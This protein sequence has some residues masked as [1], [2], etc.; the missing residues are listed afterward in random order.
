[1][2]AAHGASAAC[3]DCSASSCGRAWDNRVNERILEKALSLELRHFEDSE[4]YDKMQNAR[5]EASSRPLSLVMQA[6]GVGPERR[7]PGRPLRAPAPALSLERPG[8]GGASACPPSWPR[9]ASPAS[10]FRLVHLAGAGGA[11]AQLPR[12][13]PH[14]R[15]PREGGEALRPGAARPGPLPRALRP[16]LRRGPPPGRAPHGRGVR[17]RPPLA[18]R[19]S[20]ACTRWWRPG[21][22]AATITLGDLT[23]YLAGLPPGAG[24]G[25]GHPG[26]RS[27][28]STRTRSTCRTSSPSWP[29]RP[30]ASGPGARPPW[31]RPRGGPPHRARPRLLPL[32]RARGLGAARGVAHPRAGR[33]ARPG[34]RERRRQEHAGEAPAAPLRPDRGGH[35][36]RAASTCA[37][38][39]R[40]T[41]RERVGAVFQ[42]FVRYQFTAA[43]ERRA[44]QPAAPRRPPPHRGGGAARRRR[45]GGR[46]AA[47]RL[48]HR[49]RR[50]VRGRARALGRPV[51]E[52]GGGPRPSCAT[53]G[54]V[55]LLVL[56]EPTAAIDAEAEHELFERFRE[57]AAG[58][59]AIVISHRFSTVR[60]RRPDRRAARRA[61][62]W[63]WAATGSCSPWADATRTSSAS[64]RPGTWIEHGEASPPE[65]ESVRARGRFPPVSTQPPR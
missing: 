2:A 45:R 6:F 18:G 29:S 44:G 26:A 62:W 11:P 57:L 34:G 30:A 15:Q 37:T 32:P 48:R 54:E 5:R 47:A 59:T 58:R 9:R 4:V 65:R 31:R 27:A 60:H 63:S 61:G 1:M 43:R 3:W 53:G 25:P 51:A 17:L 41:L 46:G 7:H 64:R 23:L 36:L 10:R 33:E 56:D 49:P 12:V 28:A 52:A 8:G 38:W 16:L 21:P 22:P 50:L 19:A 14:P 13:D 24:G 55:E 40:P 39:T 20:T 42:D 35:P